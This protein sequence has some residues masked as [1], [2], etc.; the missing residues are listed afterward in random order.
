MVNEI[1]DRAAIRL[2][3]KR[4]ALLWA[5]TCAGRILL[6]LE[7]FAPVALRTV[8]ELAFFAFLLAITAG[9]I[10][11]LRKAATDYRGPIQQIQFL[12]ISRSTRIYS[13][14]SKLMMGLFMFCLVFFLWDT[15]NDNQML[16]P[17][18][19]GVAMNLWWV[20]IFAA[21]TLRLRGSAKG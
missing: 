16:L 17:M 10:L 12:K 4:F 3:T 21:R 8:T 13:R 5:I 1:E 15:R 14:S 11:I 19:V 20:W 7:P 2:L 18:V 6:A 9:E